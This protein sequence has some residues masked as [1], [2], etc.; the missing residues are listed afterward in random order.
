MSKKDIDSEEF[1]PK[2][3]SSKILADL[4]EIDEYEP[5]AYSISDSRPKKKDKEDTDEIDRRSEDWLATISSM[6]MDPIKPSK[7]D[8]GVDIFNPGKKKKKKKKKGEEEL[9]DYSEMF[10]DEMILYTDALKDTS[11]FVSSLQKRYNELDNMKSS[12]RGVGKFTTDMVAGLNQARSTQIDIIKKRADLK[13]QIAELSMKEKKD[14]INKKN[15]DTGDVGLYA[16]NALKKMIASEIGSSNDIDDLDI[17]DGNIEDLFNEINEGLPRTDDDIE[18]EKQI[19]GELVGAT[20]YA[21]IPSNGDIEDSY[22]EAYDRDQNLLDD[23]PLPEM[24]KLVVNQATGKAV[25]TYKR[26]FDIMWV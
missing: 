3:R 8:R 12:Q 24:T 1:V 9:T 4:D 16:S 26:E 13:K 11:N 20:V 5:I 10:E 17:S 21:C 23:Y 22:F 25:D 6:K 7:R 15:E 14:F 19:A 2:R 18:F